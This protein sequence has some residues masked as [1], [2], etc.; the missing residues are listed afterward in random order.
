MKTGTI[1]SIDLGY[2]LV[3]ADGSTPEEAQRKCLEMVRQLISFET[4]DT[5][6]GFRIPQHI[7]ADMPKDLPNNCV[8]I[9]LER[10]SHNSYGYGRS[11]Y[12]WRFVAVPK[13]GTIISPHDG[14][15][16]IVKSKVVSFTDS[17]SDYSYLL[18]EGS[19]VWDGSVWK[20]ANKVDYDY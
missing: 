10:C 20:P 5:D 12:D 1:A 11:A 18:P 14:K 13:G 4:I 2:R 3:S 16:K 8:R 19:F 15:L 7:F 17:N 9:C 6:T